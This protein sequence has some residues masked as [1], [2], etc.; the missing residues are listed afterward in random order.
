LEYV[1]YPEVLDTAWE[2]TQLLRE[3]G[4]E[5]LEFGHFNFVTKSPNV[6]FPTLRMKFKK[7]QTYRIYLI[8]EFG[9]DTL[10]ITYNEG[11]F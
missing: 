3:N 10:T 11:D 1:F 8:N 6:R 2:L 5:L 9:L 7:D 4:F